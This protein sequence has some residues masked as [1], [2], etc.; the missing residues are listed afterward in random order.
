MYVMVCYRPDIA[1]AV[2]Q[3]SRFMAQPSREHWGA[4]KEIF[5]YLVGTVRVVICYRQ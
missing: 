4:L 2:S 1:P 5:R 3:V